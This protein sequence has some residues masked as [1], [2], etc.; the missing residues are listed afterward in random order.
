MIFFVYFRDDSE[1]FSILKGAIG[2]PTHL[3]KV[4][5]AQTDLSEPQIHVRY[6]KFRIQYPT[7]F[8]GPHI[9][10]NLLLDVLSE[11]ECDEY[12]DM[13]FKIYGQRKKGWGAKLIGF[14]E[15][16]LAT[17]GTANSLAFTDR[18]SY[19]YFE[20]YKQKFEF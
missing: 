7:G 20:F 15:V 10:R 19:D 18:Q 12:V 16:V 1:E 13:V 17:E 4:V 11:K 8:V 5:S 6:I 9:L 3:L 2:C 14:R